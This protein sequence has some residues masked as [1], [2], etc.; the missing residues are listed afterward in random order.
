[1]VKIISKLPMHYKYMLSYPTG[2]TKVNYFIV[3]KSSVVAH[4]G[5]EG[6]KEGGIRRNEV[7]RI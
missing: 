4:M 2:T 7:G 6:M 5:E 3:L 1:M